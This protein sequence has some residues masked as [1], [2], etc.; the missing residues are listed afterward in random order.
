SVCTGCSRGCSIFVDFMGQDTYRY[1]PRENEAINK[2]WMCDQ[3]RLSYKYVNQHRLVA[4]MVGRGEDRREATVPEA[5]KSVVEQFR[6][7][8]GPEG[9]GVLV[10]PLAWTGDLLAGLAFARD[11][12]GVRS[13]Y[14]GGRPD[15][16]GDHYLMTPDKNPNR[17]GLEW[18]A[19]GLDL[20]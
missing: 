9:R 10:S 5:L 11:A 1:R 15:G 3:G 18:V 12:L 13:V 14:V 7:W 19:R 20:S 16:A 8:G 4:A 17:R 6:P 2:S